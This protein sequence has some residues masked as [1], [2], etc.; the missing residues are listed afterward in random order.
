[1]LYIVFEGDN[2]TGKTTQIGRVLGLLIKIFQEKQDLL[3][4]D[5]TIHK[6]HEGDTAHQVYDNWYAKVLDYARDRA[7]MQHRIHPEYSQNITLSDRSYYTSLV[8]QGRDDKIDIEYIRMVNQ[9]AIEPDIII[10][11]SNNDESEIYKRYCNVL[12][13]GKVWIFNTE[14]NDISSTTK[15]I[16][17]IIL[18]EWLMKYRDCDL[19][20]A[21]NLSEEIIEEY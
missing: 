10:L 3:K 6:F 4:H 9:F 8:Y 16:V 17:D 13:L 7:V 18:F 15:D 20:E 19:E 12:P 11:L 21:F 5:I 14:V 1:M 2:G